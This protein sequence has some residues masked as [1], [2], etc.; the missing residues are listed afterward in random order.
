MNKSYNDEIN[1]KQQRRNAHFVGKITNKNLFCLFCSKV[2]FDPIL[3]PCSCGTTVCKSCML[4]W[5]SEKGTIICP[6]DQK[7]LHNGLVDFFVN[8]LIPNRQLQGC[9]NQLEI[10]CMNNNKCESEDP[11]V[12]CNWVGKLSKWE[13]HSV[14]GCQCRMDVNPS[15]K[16][17]HAK[18]LY[19]V[20][21]W[22]MIDFSLSNS[23]DGS[24]VIVNKDQVLLM[25]KRHVMF[26]KEGDFVNEARNTFINSSTVKFYGKDHKVAE[27]E[28]QQLL[29]NGRV[30]ISFQKGDLR[31]RLDMLI[32]NKDWHQKIF[33]LQ[34]KAGT[35]VSH[36]EEK[37]CCVRE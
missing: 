26:L 25:N 19:C 36:K 10:T 4:N 13:T 33:W 16:F 3:L 5:V 20:I 32:E 37:T 6:Y 31:R 1:K 30:T 17:D 12:K 9:I 34:Q 14:N 7:I 28:I 15:I 21:F 22:E 24:C 8:N 27:A 23:Q 2:L 29:A 35:D 18:M 11:L